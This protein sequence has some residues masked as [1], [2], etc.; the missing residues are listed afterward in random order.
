[1]EP[2]SDAPTAVPELERGMLF[3]S[4]KVLYM[5]ASHFTRKR[6]RAA[7]AEA[8]NE[9]MKLGSAQTWSLF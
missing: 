8:Q 5:L 9:R 1:M 7:K 3:G 6:G 4:S 2:V